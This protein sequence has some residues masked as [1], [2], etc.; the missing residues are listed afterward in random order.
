MTVTHSLDNLSTWIG[1]ILVL[2]VITTSF[3][4]LGYHLICSWIEAATK[5]IRTHDER[6]R[7]LED[8]NDVRKTVANT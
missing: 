7:K 3:S 6:L 1:I 2:L 4:L 5:V 8:G